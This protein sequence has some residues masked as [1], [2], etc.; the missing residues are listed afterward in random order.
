[1][2]LP[3]ARPARTPN[4]GARATSGK[5]SDRNADYDPSHVRALFPAL[6]QTIRGKPLVYLDSAASTQKPRTVIDAIV[7]FYEADNANVHRGV[8]AARATTLRAALRTRPAC[9]P[10]S[11]SST[12]ASRR[13]S[14]SSA[15]RPRRSTS[16]RKPLAARMLDRA[17]RC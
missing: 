14:S 16:S 7:R 8:H 6:D 4:H 10:F 5:P 2:S 3:Q 9:K 11:S 1:M 12:P 17:T 15:A 13:K